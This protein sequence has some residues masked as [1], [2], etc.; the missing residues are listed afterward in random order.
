MHGEFDGWGHSKAA[1]GLVVDRQKWRHAV[2]VI[3][4]TVHVFAMVIFVLERLLRFAMG[5]NKH[6][7]R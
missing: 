3:P 7:D 6:V 4:C 5:R 2:E 1:V